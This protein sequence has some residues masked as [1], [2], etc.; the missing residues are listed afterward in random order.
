MTE[1]KIRASRL[2]ELMDRVDKLNRRAKRINLAPISVEIG[3]VETERYKDVDDRPQVLVWQFIEVSGEKPKLPGWDFLG[4][5]R[6]EPGGVVWASAETDTEFVLPNEYRLEDGTRCDHCHTKRMRRDTFLLR[7][8]E[9]GQFQLIGRNCLQ[10]FIGSSDITGFIQQFEFCR[11]VDELGEGLDED[12]YGRGGR[13]PYVDT[14]LY[15]EA[16]ACAIRTW[17]WR[18]RTAARDSLGGQATAEDAWLILQP[19]SLQPKGSPAPVPS[20]EDRTTAAAALAWAQALPG[21]TDYERNLLVLV[22]EVDFFHF[23]HDGLMASAVAGYLR[24]QEELK[25]REAKAKLCKN[26]HFGTIKKRALLELTV[27]TVR[28][29]ATDSYFSPVRYLFRFRDKEGRLAIW[30]TGKSDDEAG[31]IEGG[32]YVVLATV[33]DHGEYK[34]EKQTVLTRVAKKSETQPT[35]LAEQTS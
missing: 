20:L 32:K 17:G 2:S 23:R 6:H 33:K 19:P 28:S 27:E 25:I 11:L 13:S 26:E 18:S 22:Q 1:F 10:D 16:V 8:Q 29:F 3:R 5:L 9:T 14:L 35:Q 15:L 4:A 21:D 34:G 24:S 31:L 12:S 30:W 7:K